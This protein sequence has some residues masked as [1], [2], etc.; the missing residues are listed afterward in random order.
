[1]KKVKIKNRNIVI[2]GV[3]IV[4]TIL[5]LI[6]YV[7]NSIKNK[8]VK[9]AVE[10][11]ECIFYKIDRSKEKNFSKDIYISIPIKPV[12]TN[13]YNNQSYYENLIKVITSQLNNTNYR[14][15]DEEK[16]LVIRVKADN[17]NV[18]YTINGDNNYYQTKMAEGSF[19]NTNEEK[20]TELEVK[21][22]ELNALINENWNR[23]N[24][25]NI[26]GSIDD[27]ENQ[28]ECYV[29]EGYKI[30]IVNLKVFNIVFT[31]QY[32]GEV[33]SE[34]RTGL[35]NLEVQEKLGNP[36]FVGEEKEV[37]GYKT[38][39]YYV[40]FYNGEISIYRIEEL[41]E[42]DNQKFASLVTE[43][44]NKNDLDKFISDV[45]D[46]YHDYDEFIQD[47]NGIRLSYT[48]RGFEINYQKDGYSGI[49]IYNNYKG[50]ITDEIS[51]EDIKNGKTLPR[52]I[53]SGSID[54]VFEYELKK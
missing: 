48:L 10:D 26:L 22:N 9:K 6:M 28:Y 3:A 46:L 24:I 2:A 34:I 47:E 49:T 31:D 13:T 15:I 33:F 16:E 44:L 38:E 14:L 51:V 35:S 53:Y 5:C 45:T 32:Q 52:K 21:S 41:N 23:A 29:D 4:I 17:K 11:M 18:K 42:D 20:N 27:N 8:N 43:L 1:M 37:I 25:R 30:R 54:K 39:Q 7:D 12:E 40:F 50:K 19:K 36:I